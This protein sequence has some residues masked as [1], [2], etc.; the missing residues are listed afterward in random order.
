MP[1]SAWRRIARIWGSLYLVIFIQNL[2]V[3]LAE[4]I[5]LIKPLNLGG[6]T[7]VYLP[8]FLRLEQELEIERTKIDALAR[9]RSY[10]SHPN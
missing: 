8:I 1:P 3:H 4:K 10:L 6:I 9:A 7:H 5:L 2:L